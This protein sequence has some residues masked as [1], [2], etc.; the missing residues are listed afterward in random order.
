MRIISIGHA[1]LLIEAAGVRILCDPWFLPAFH[2]SWFPFPRNDR[3]DRELLARIERPDYLYV[4]HQ[5]GDHLD[6]PWLRE[7]VARDLVVLLPA[8]ETDELERDLRQL[9]FGRFVRLPDAEAVR[10]TP[11][12]EVA[13][14][15]ATS[16]AD[17]PGGDSA[18]VVSDGECRILNQN[19]CHLRDLQALTRH[20]PIDVHMLQ[21]SGAIWWPFVY[22][23]D[24]R[25]L[26]DLARAKRQGQYD[27]ALRY[28]QAV[29]ARVVVGMAG[30]PA[31][32]DE[33]LFGLNMITGEELSIFP[34][35]RDFHDLLVEH[36]RDSVVLL[37]GSTLT[38]GA[39]STAVGHATDPDAPFI[40]KAAYLRTY[41]RDWAPWL[42]QL[43]RSW[44]ATTTDLLSGLRAWWHPLLAQAP[45]LR[46][47]IGAGCLIVSDPDRIYVDFP[48]GEVR[49]HAGEAYAHRF[50]IPRP[51]LEL[52]VRERAVDWSN[53][54]F[55]S[56]RFRAWRAGAY[57]E[58]LYAFFKSLSPQRMA[59]A[60]AEAARARVEAPEVPMIAL[61]PYRVERWCPHRQAD[62][63]EFGVLDNDEVVCTMHGWRFDARTGGCRNACGRDLV[64]R[65]SADEV[66]ERGEPA[67]P[68]PSC[69]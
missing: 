18:L 22:E 15:V 66:E 59:R 6:V 2:G 55:L 47:A 39:D 64:V 45:G 3:L 7:H 44:P 60:E 69:N 43:K 50:T 11:R 46:E 21:F 32:L 58:H 63:A 49:R 31:F 1:G 30:P 57:S 17:G 33:E 16:V 27:R 37:P 5:H 12:L 14:H 52:V 40:D 53:R 23:L 4:S 42:E 26:A 65:P 20:G 38:V 62:L 25:R 68:D 67:S 35:Q 19:D 9:G 56:C 48:A 34:D 8:F 24:E 54:L 41:Q 28:V 61:G 29:N 10:L 13:I 51:L 36:G